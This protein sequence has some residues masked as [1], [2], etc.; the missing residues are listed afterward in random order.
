MAKKMIKVLID[1]EYQD[2]ADENSCTNS[3][4]DE[5][6][7]IIEAGAIVNSFDFLHVL[8]NVDGISCA[9]ELIAQ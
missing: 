5:V 9:F 6:M 8:S 1:L 3:M 7:K 4:A 2:T